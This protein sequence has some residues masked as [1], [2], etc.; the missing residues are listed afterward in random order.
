MPG[1]SWD[2]LADQHA[3]A[4]GYLQRFVD[5]HGHARV[6]QSE[7]IDGFRLGMWVTR[8]RADRRSGRLDA[9]LEAQ[10]EAIPGWSWDPR[11]ARVGEAMVLLQRFVDLHGHA[12]VPESEVIDGFNLGMWVATRRADRRRSQLDADLEAQLEAIPGWSWDP[13]ADQLAEAMRF[14][15]RFVD[16]HGHARVPHSEV[17]DG[18]NLGAW[19]SRRQASQRSGRLD[20]DLEARLEALPGWSWG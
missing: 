18:F 3:E 13:G 6:P 12:R 11:R 17:I 19:V 20:A 5:L 16:L 14:L 15:Q 7:V 2:P 8:R 9:D 4:M 10:L 1:W